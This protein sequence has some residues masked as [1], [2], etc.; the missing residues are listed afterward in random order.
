[1]ENVCE[2]NLVMWTAGRIRDYKMQLAMI[3][4][5]AASNYRPVLD[6]IYPNIQPDSSCT[7]EN[8]RKEMLQY[9]RLSNVY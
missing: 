5:S 1:M 3:W 4:P 8:N 6:Q 9:I 2:T 7:I